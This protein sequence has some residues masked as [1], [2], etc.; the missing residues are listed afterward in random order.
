MSVSISDWVRWLS[1]LVV[2][3][4]AVAPTL[5]AEH[6]ILISLVE[7]LFKDVDVRKQG[8]DVCLGKGSRK[9]LAADSVH[10]S[11]PPT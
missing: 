9:A 4:D 6:V 11:R 7:G 1:G 3:K 5:S 10:C 8:G 2:A